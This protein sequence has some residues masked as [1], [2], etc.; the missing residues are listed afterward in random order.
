MTKY[1]RVMKVLKGEN[2][3]FIPTGFW[4]H[5]PKETLESVDKTIT[6]HM[7]FLK[8]TDIDLFK[9]M[10]ENEFRISEKINSAVDWKKITVYE[11][12]D[13]KI[14]TQ[15]ELLKRILEINSKNTVVL[16]TVHGLI[17]CLSHQSGISYSNSYKLMNEHFKN[18]K[19]EIEYALDKTVESII[20]MAEETFDA[21]VDGIYYAALGGEKT[22]FSDEI[23]EEFIKPRELEIFK[24][25]KR[26]N[27]L[28]VLHICKENTELK[29]Y[30]DYDF[31]IVNWAV[32]DGGYSLLEGCNLF[33]DKT[34][35]G[36]FD[37]RSGILVD[38]TIDEIKG[39]TDELI[40]TMKGHKFIIGA[41]CT[42]PTEISYQRIKEVVNQSKNNLYK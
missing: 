27:K 42:L 5:F 26:K 15:K 14:V 25:L 20:N 28:N 23:F 11:K 30:I 32:N 13:K 2:V 38:G 34:I 33:K 8:E 39:Y 9:V 17:A 36:G 19:N 21:G 4:L 1:E 24:V 22:K 37:D 18:N 3:D 12:N 10:N 7:E 41:D 29:R 31:D 16:G 6:A 35:L 40:E